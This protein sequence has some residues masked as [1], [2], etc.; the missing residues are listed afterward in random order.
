MRIALCFC[1]WI[2]WMS[3]FAQEDDEIA[4][5]QTIE[6][7]FEGFHEQDSIKIKQTTYGN[8]LL[9]TV[10]TDSVGTANLKTE[11]FDDFL[12]S[13]VSIPKTVQFQ[14]KLVSFNIQID[15]KMAHAWTPYEFWI[16]EKFSHCGVNSFQLLKE[17]DL[18]KI[19]YLIDTR[20]KNGCN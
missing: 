10:A 13:I 2:C 12:K 6:R 17:E 18:W 1:V 19:I 3:V 11:A 8:I 14:E 9:Q 7:F 20:R 4:I 15:G 5:Q 16:N